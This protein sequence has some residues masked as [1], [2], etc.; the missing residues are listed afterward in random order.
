MRKQSGLQPED[1]R[2]RLSPHLGVTSVQFLLT[3][4]PGLFSAMRSFAAGFGKLGNALV[5]VQDWLGKL[6]PASLFEDGNQFVEL[7]PRVRAGNY[8][9]Y[10]MEQLFAFCAGFG[11]Y[12]IDNFFELLGC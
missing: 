6:E 11:F 4:G 5:D 2:G 7:G 10:G 1:S 9:A 3:F 8:Q 12:F